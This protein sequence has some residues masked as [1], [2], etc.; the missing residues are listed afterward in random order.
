MAVGR[1]SE[2]ISGMTFL[3]VRHEE[4]KTF[5]DL[6]AWP[7]PNK[8]RFEKKLEDKL[9]QK[10]KSGISASLVYND[11]IQVRDYFHDHI[12]KIASILD[13]SLVTGVDDDLLIIEDE[14]QHYVY[15][16]GMT[17]TLVYIACWMVVPFDFQNKP[18]LLF[19]FLNTYYAQQLES[20]EETEVNVKELEKY[21]NLES[22]PV[23][24]KQP[25][26][27][28]SSSSGSES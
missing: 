19:W 21:A 4:E 27:Y 15:F 24:V 3:G 14:Q 16:G 5:I 23:Q 13:L 25:S 20:L 9:K 12:T 22:R 17:R 8:E 28:R 26:L 1:T 10:R 2:L 6:F 11:H 18:K 7:K